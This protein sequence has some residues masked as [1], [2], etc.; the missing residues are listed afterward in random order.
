[1]T[2]PITA[3]ELNTM[4]ADAYALTGKN[5][6]GVDLGHLRGH[7][8]RLIGE[9]WRLRAKVRYG[10]ASAPVV[11]SATVDELES[12]C[13]RLDGHLVRLH[14]RMQELAAEAKRDRI[15]ASNRHDSEAAVEATAVED[16][17]ERALKLFDEVVDPEE[18]E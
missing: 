4:A 3:D 11:S 1:M 16:G 8:M 12:R 5:P 17:W 9:V 10:A 18:P 14:Y 15:D 13:D 7:F 2:K 6:D